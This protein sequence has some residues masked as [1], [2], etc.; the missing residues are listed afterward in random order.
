MMIHNVETTL[1][2]RRNVGWE[3]N[4]PLLP[5]VTESSIVGFVVDLD[6]PLD[7]NCAYMYFLIGVNSLFIKLVNITKET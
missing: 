6:E 7:M 5:F 4:N 1:I 3:V 2:R